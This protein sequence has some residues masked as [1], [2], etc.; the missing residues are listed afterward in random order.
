[1][2]WKKWREQK[3]RT[4]G[5][6]EKHGL[7]EGQ[8]T[9]GPSLVWKRVESLF[10]HTWPRRLL[11]SSTTWPSAHEKLCQFSEQGKDSCRL[12]AMLLW[13]LLLDLRELHAKS[14]LTCTWIETTSTEWSTN[15]INSEETAAE[16]RKY[17]KSFLPES[18]NVWESWLLCCFWIWKHRVFLLTFVCHSYYHR[19]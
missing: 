5:G 19:N 11:Y 13:S 4:E 6:K 15:W 12:I 1:M 17:C 9:E 14:I 7:M 10:C 8:R 18:L 2:V 3:F 16:N